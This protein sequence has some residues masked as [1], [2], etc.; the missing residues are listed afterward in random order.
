MIKDSH[1]VL[2][3]ESLPNARL[4]RIKGDHFIA[5]KNPEEFNQAVSRFLRNCDSIV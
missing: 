4:V 5:A 3:C 2:I 1:S